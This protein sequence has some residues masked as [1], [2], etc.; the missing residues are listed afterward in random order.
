MKQHEILQKF[1]IGLNKGLATSLVVVSPA[2]T[3]K[4]EVTMKTLQELG[5]VEHQNFLYIPN[6]ITPKA[7][8][9]ELLRVNEL[10]EPRILILDDAEDTLKNLQ[11]IGILKGALWQVGNQRR[12]SWITSR[13]RIEFDFQGRIIFL[14]NKLSKDNQLVN[15]FIDRG[16]FYAM[17]FKNWELLE[18]MKE[19]LKMPYHN[20]NYFQRQKIFQI[21]AKNGLTSE[22][23]SLRILPQAFNLFILSPNHFQ[24]LVLKLL[25]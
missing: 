15:A 21:I 2:G 8:V 22:K 7:L 20:L 6:Y 10:K 16:L 9:Q 14:L 13:Q 4:T 23:L 12:V 1:I 11:S 3:G 17:E 25:R 19:R 24:E 18:L 5:L